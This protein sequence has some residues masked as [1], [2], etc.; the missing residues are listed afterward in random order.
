MSTNDYTLSLSPA[1][2]AGAPRR[3]PIIELDAEHYQLID[4][5]KLRFPYGA[6]SLIQCTELSLEGDIRFGKNV[7]LEGGVKLVNPDPST[8][9][10]IPDGARVNGMGIIG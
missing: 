2:T 10:E 4:D 6:P 3:P 1:R 8:P 5:L 7:V 9:L